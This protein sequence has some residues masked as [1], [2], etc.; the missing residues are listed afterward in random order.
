MKSE[1]PEEEDDVSDDGKQ[2]LIKELS[3]R[4]LHDLTRK[5]ADGEYSDFGSP[6]G[7]WPLPVT[8][9]VEDL[10][11]AGHNDLASRAMR[12]DFDHDQ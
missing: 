4:G 7:A 6:H 8:Q 2:K 11:A 10:K 12:G 9:L 1:E 5:V 3:M